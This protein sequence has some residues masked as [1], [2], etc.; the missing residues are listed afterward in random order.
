MNS[1]IP[2]N[3]ITKLATTVAL[4][5]VVLYFSGLFIVFSEIKKMENTYNST[6]SDS[7]KEK[8]IAF[9][10][11]ITETNKESIQTLQ[12]FFIQK[13]DEVKFIEQIE[14]IAKESAVKFEIS[15]IDV[16]VSQTNSFKEDVD[17][18]VKLEGSWR[19]VIYFMDKL[20]K[21]PFG[22]SVE[23]VNLNINTRND[24]SGSVE[25]IVFREK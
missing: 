24:W 23:D 1:W 6:E 20:E 15:S 14:K 10:K 3:K 17:V 16:K 19:D 9:I 11:S 5:S 13:G 12:N 21:M 4:F 18:K 7:Y 8:K 25:F 2:K 22:V